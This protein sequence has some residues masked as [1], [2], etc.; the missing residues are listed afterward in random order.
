MTMKKHL[1]FLVV[2]A[3]GVALFVSPLDAAGCKKAKQEN[4]ELRDELETYRSMNA[5]LEAQILERERG[6]ADRNQELGVLQDQLDKKNSELQSL[7]DEIEALEMNVYELGESLKARG[8]SLSVQVA[9]LLEKK[10]DLEN[11]IIALKADIDSAYRRNERLGQLVN[12]YEARVGVLS[13]EMEKLRSE[14]DAL[15]AAEEEDRKRMASTYDQ[16]IESLGMEIGQQTVEIQ[17]YRDSLTI[18]IMDK[19]FFDSGKAEIKPS[20]YDV[21]RRVGAI[22][23]EVPDKVIR[24]EGH[25]DDIPIGQKIIE[26][27]PTNWELGAAR[28]ANVA[29]FLRKDV[30][31]DPKRM[32]VVSYSMYRP[33]VPHTTEANRAKNRRIEIVVLD[34]LYYQMVEVKEGMGM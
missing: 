20:G 8:D 12:G 19:I 7:Y 13:A 32:V 21:L 15:R 3:G 28:A 24:I 33:I 27:Y 30:G 25:T 26:K 16:L 1:L 18:N 10:Q 5:D 31:I 23:K 9:Q 6:L 22:L 34:K 11:Q 29:E 14:N 2:C 4:V 17:Q